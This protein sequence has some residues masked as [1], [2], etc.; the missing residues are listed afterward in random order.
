MTPTTWRRKDRGQEGFG[1][2]S[3]LAELTKIIHIAASRPSK[4]NTGP[5]LPQ[6]DE[7][8]RSIVEEWRMKTRRC[9]G[10][11]SW[12]REGELNN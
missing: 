1:K 6:T 5:K 8:L 12:R 3:Y 9:D 11:E 4:L 2:L 7:L 10:K